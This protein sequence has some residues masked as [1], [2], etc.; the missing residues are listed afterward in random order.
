MADA[1]EAV[2]VSDLVR[3][4]D[5]DRGAAFVLTQVLGLSYEETAA[6]CECPPGTIRSRVA[7]ARSDLLALLQAADGQRDGRLGD[8]PGQSSSA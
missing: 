6:I 3:R 7:R 5:P 1:S 2:T 8:R 4:L